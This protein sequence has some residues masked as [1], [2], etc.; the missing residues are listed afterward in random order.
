M[1]SFILVLQVWLASSPPALAE[2]ADESPPSDELSEEQLDEYVNRF[3]DISENA[4]GTSTA[5]FNFAPIRYRD[6]DG[7]WQDIDNT[8]MPNADFSDRQNGLLYTNSSAEVDVNLASDPS[9]DVLASVQH[10][11]KSISFK[12]VIYDNSM[13]ASSGALEQAGTGAA[14]FVY[15]PDEAQKQNAAQADRFVADRKYAALR[16]E[17]V[18]SP[19]THI[20]LTPMSSGLKEN[21]I[22][23]APASGSFTYELSLDGMYPEL[24]DDGSI[25]LY[26]DETDE[27]CGF[28]AAPCMEDNAQSPA[29]SY[30]IDVSL[31]EDDG[32]YIY[33]ITPDE[34]WLNSPERV[35]PV[36][37]DPTFTFN[38]ETYLSDT[39]IAQK[40]PT[41][42][43]VSDTHIKLGNSGTLGVSRGLFRLKS[44][45]S[46]LGSGRTIISASF[47]AYQDYTGASAPEIGLYN[48]SETYTY[49]T[50]TWNTAPACGSLIKKITVDDTGWFT[51][52]ITSKIKSWYK[53]APTVT[54]LYMR[55]V[56]E[57]ANMYKRFR[58]INYSDTAYAPKLTVVYMTKPANVKVSPTG[59]TNG[60]ITVT[61]ST[62]SVSGNTITYQYALSTS[63]TTAPTS[64]T[65]FTNP[66][67]HRTL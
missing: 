66:P 2:G 60:D 36:A 57:S 51:W 14:V 16:Y 25:F 10:S 29:E 22:L 55:N 1:L 33:R 4:D 42:C 7:S 50:V 31:A 53:T 58:S 63:N 40:Y 28:I 13:S 17:N 27:L 35:Y 65:D 44:F 45:S 47:K 19:G 24:N 34:E 48:V 67:R 49:N 23:S 26:D 3:V 43:Y 37:I 46:A 62:Q 6:D 18:F 64:F 59:W 39:F 12:P 21:I 32:K 38:T 52:D 9:N 5:V 61:H 30:D 8:I 11:G 20:E 41:N 15:T 54:A 56:S